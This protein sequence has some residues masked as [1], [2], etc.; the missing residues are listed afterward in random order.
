MYIEEPGK[1][2]KG[3]PTR[4]YLLQKG[5]NGERKDGSGKLIPGQNWQDDKRGKNGTVVGKEELRK[6]ILWTGK[7]AQPNKRSDRITQPSEREG[8]GLG[9][10]G[11]VNSQG[12]GEEKKKADLPTCGE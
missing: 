8:G 7:K 12:D 11:G 3:N 2:K 4:V 9:G 6:K 10:D 1:K 5:R